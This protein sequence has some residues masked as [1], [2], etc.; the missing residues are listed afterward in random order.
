MRIY[1]II[2]TYLIFSLSGVYAQQWLFQ[3]N[4]SSVKIPFELID[5]V[6]V[7]PV[8]LNGEQMSFVLDTGVKETM[9]FG[10]VDSV[11]LN[12]VSSIKFQG[13]GEEKSIEGLLSLDNRISLGDSVMFDLHHNLYVITDSAVNLS[14]NL[15]VPI[16]GI[17][18]ST[19]FAN[20]IV[21]IDYIKQEITVSRNLDGQARKIKKFKRVP[22]TIINSRPFVNVDIKGFDSDFK[23]SRM[24]I[25]IGNSD[26]SMI[27]LQRLQQHQIHKPSIYEFL[28]KGFNGNI[29]GT[30]SRLKGIRI[31]DF[32]IDNP[33]VSY[34]DS[35]GYAHG[36]L[37]V[38]RVGSVGNQIMSR[39]DVIFNYSDSC[40]Y[41]RK[42]KDFNNPFHVDMSGLDIRHDGFVF[43]ETPM[44]N[45]R[46]SNVDGGV[47][48]DMDAIVRY[49]IELV[50]SFVVHH[51]RVGSPAFD[52]GIK[53][54]DAFHKI[55]GRLAGKLSLD[56][57][58]E[59]F[60]TKDQHMVDVEVIRKEK[61][62][63]FR[64]KL[65]DP[66]AIE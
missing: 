22:I 14:N 2:F 43:I 39:F 35:A 58:K 38:N 16:H 57:I 24:L 33:I 20:N 11:V 56:R 6:I 31:A 8:M 40:M 13:L 63:R 51:V 28:G 12:N 32:N 9:L 4:K 60:Q 30:R 26:P 45:S 54:G 1:L 21:Q 49:K 50:P 27:F 46:V 7:L 10:S 53:V 15:G 23:D 19:F 65:T 52:A 48:V 44:S 37:V 3:S 66:L 41:L 64:F 25:D 17:L 55:N 62:L 59:N 34:P 29:Y 5:H 18:G 36:K 42:N 61:K 47:R